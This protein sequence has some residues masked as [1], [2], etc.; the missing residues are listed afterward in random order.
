MGL[1]LGYTIPTSPVAEE[2]GRGFV[3]DRLIPGRKGRQ[4]S[5]RRTV[6]DYEDLTK[7]TGSGRQGERAR[8]AAGD[9]QNTS[10]DGDRACGSRSDLASRSKASKCVDRY[11][12]NLRRT[13]SCCGYDRDQIIAR[14]RQRLENWDIIKSWHNG[15]V[16]VLR[17]SRYGDPLAV[18]Y[19][20]GVV[21][22]RLNKMTKP[23]SVL[24]G[25]EAEASTPRK[26]PLVLS[27]LMTSSAMLRQPNLPR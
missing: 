5:R 16:V 25:L 4:G 11:F 26:N 18:S 3:G 7:R 10:A 14:R 12:T 1:G 20:A 13:G 9:N 15:G 24:I 8:S 21:L 27:G 19:A 17:G 23:N 2:V 22:S 6:V